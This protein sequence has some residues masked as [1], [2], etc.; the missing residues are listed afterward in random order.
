MQR[1]WVQWGGA[2]AAAM[3]ALLVAAPVEGADQ[4]GVR[5]VAEELGQRTKPA[6]AP[7][8]EQKSG[9]LSD[10][11][12]RVLMTYALSIIPESYPGPDG[13]PIKVEK[14]DPN[15]FV[16][17]VD[18]ARRVVRAATRSAYAEVCD[19]KDL[20]RANFQAL[21]RSEEAKKLWSKDQMLMISALHMFSVSYFTGS[22]KITTSTEDGKPQAGGA[23]AVP[24]SKDGQS[25][26]SAGAEAQGGDTQVLA[27]KR[28]TCSPDQ[29][30]KVTN[31]IN[32]FVAANPVAEAD[33]K[34][35]QAA[36]PP[37]AQAAPP[38]ATATGSN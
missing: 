17:P 7:E 29:K 36:K 28:P 32:A 20:E 30:V 25:A 27:P 16:I 9:G 18:D 2:A 38:P 3:F 1:A 14:G 6:A 35:P 26:N 19:L 5:P 12:V 33:P 31:A 8:G 34:T 15:K 4:S 24:V 37:K 10:S 11:A 13:K 21:M 22:I 23:G